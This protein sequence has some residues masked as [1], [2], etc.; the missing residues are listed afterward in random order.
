MSRNRD[1]ENRGQRYVMA[2]N[3]RGSS[4]TADMGTDPDDG[5]PCTGLPSLAA[6]AKAVNNEVIVEFE[7]LFDRLGLRQIEIGSFFERL[8]GLI[9]TGNC[10]DAYMVKLFDAAIYEPLLC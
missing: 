9:E 2:K 8:N 1:K 3:R 4:R 10:S 5:R 6:R 7:A